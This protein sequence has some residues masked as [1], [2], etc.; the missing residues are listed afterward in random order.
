[1][2]YSADGGEA[3]GGASGGSGTDVAPLLVDGKPHLPFQ[4][5]IE[6]TGQD[7]SRCMRVITQ[8]KPITTDRVVAEG[9][10]CY[11][12]YMCVYLE[13]HMLVYTCI[14]AIIVQSHCTH[15]KMEGPLLAQKRTRFIWRH[16]YTNVYVQDINMYLYIYMYMYVEEVF[17]YY[18]LIHVYNSQYLCVQIWTCQWLEL[19]WHTQQPHWPWG[20]STPRPDSVLSPHRDCSRRLGEGMREEE[21]IEL[22]YRAW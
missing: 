2:F 1:M 9:G 3:S 10:T 14:V 12:Y 21:Y 18:I 17:G 6:Y 13:Y 15:S 16:N 22:H 19:T 5:Q 20:E 7:G 4:L 11:M 8:A